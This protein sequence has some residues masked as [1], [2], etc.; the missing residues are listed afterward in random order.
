M[1]IDSRD[2]SEG[3]VVSHPRCWFYDPYSTYEQAIV[4]E[5]LTVERVEEYDHVNPRANIW[6][7]DSE[8]KVRAF[9]E[10]ELQ[11]YNC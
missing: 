9:K 11:S 10:T 1:P 6:V 5:C 4:Y 7:R 8:G 3:M 2:L